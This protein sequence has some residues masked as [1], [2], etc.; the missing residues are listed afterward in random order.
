MNFYL[1]LEGNIMA[2]VFK[3]TES[4]RVSSFDKINPEGELLITFAQFPYGMTLTKVGK[5]RWAI[6]HSYIYDLFITSLTPETFIYGYSKDY[7]LSVIDRDGNVLFKFSIDESYHPITGKEKDKVR[8]QF[9][10]VPDAVKKAIQFPPH[11]PFFMGI[12]CD[13]TERI[14]VMRFKSILDER[15]GY[16][17]DIFS[18]DGYYL[19]KTHIPYYPY[20]IKNG[21]LYTHITLEETGEE[22]I[23]RFRIKN[24]SNIKENI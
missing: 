8:D 15:K 11:K 1:D 12:L 19:Y 2:R 14:Y 10:R 20:I 24:W 17:F 5:T 21:S 23:K 3:S 18:K 13:D 7:E 4:G 9:K 6:S 16:D 22:L